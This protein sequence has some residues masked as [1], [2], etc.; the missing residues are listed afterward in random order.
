[1]VLSVLKLKYY[2]LHLN[3][4]FNFNLRRS[5]L[6]SLDDLSAQRLFRKAS[7]ALYRIPESDDGDDLYIAADENLPLERRP[8]AGPYTRSHFRST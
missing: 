4:A 8:T 6:V 7:L 2:E 1:M 3:F 5:I